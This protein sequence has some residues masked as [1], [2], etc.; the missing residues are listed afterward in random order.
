[1]TSPPPPPSSDT[2]ADTIELLESR[3][4]RIE[5]LLTGEASWT[6][7]SGVRNW[8]VAGAGGNANSE[9][10]PATTRLAELEYELKSLAKKVPAVRD[11]LALYTR[12]PDLF[13][14]T[15]PTTTPTTLP[16]QSLTSIILSYA[17]AFPETASRLTSLQDLPIP[18]AALSAALIELQP[19]LD[20]LAAVQAQQA[21][22]VAELRVRSAL[23]A[24]R[25]VEVGVVGGSEVW[26]E[27]EG[28]VEGVER[29]VRRVEGGRR[30]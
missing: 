18:P 13:Q 4:R 29:G 2:A 11:V 15:P 6:G 16:P 20:R 7:E 24:K 10:Q 3:L 25:W 23:V 8:N 19:R 9:Q 22:E 26:G 21:A 27:W 30:E 14:P 5:Y 28:R 1:M 12:F 17:S